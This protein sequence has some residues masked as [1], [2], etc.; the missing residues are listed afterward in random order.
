ME[1]TFKKGL[2]LLS[3]DWHYDR[4]QGVGEHVEPDVTDRTG[5]LLFDEVTPD[6]DAMTAGFAVGQIAGPVLVWLIG[7]AQIASWNALSWAYAVATV[8]LAVTLLWL[9]GTTLAVTPKR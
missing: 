2:R 1:L 3:R 6:P 7:C 4:V 9:W 8:L 5:Q